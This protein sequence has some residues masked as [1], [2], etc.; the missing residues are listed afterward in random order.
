MQPCEKCDALLSESTSASPHAGLS[1]E[2]MYAYRG[3]ELE[4]YTCGQCGIAW[5]RLKT[6]GGE[7]KW[8]MLIAYG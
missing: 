3:G 2:A 5:D 1:G 7:Q 4:R 8:R 6:T